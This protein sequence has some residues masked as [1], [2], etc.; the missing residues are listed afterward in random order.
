M[1]QSDQEFRRDKRETFMTRTPLAIDSGIGVFIENSSTIDIS[2]T[3]VRLRLRSRIVPGQMVDVFLN[4][5][6]QRCRIV[7]TDPAG[8][9]N[10]LIAGL[11]FIRQLP[12][13]RHH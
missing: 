11:Q 12:D 10:E 8:V 13:S 9:S 1:W 6:P 2:E 5:R 7:W 4:N 3:G